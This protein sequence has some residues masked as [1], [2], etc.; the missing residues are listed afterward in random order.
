MSHYKHL[1]TNEREKL[2]VLK[3]NGMGIR[4]IAKQ[5][6]RSAATISRELRRNNSEEGYWP[7]I[8]QQLYS[9]R[10]KSCRRK[11]ILD[12]P[13]KKAF[14]QDK[15]INDQWSPEQIDGRTALENASCHC[16]YATIYRAINAGRMEV[17]ELRHGQRGI[18][19][20]LRHK[21]K[22]RHKKGT[23]EKRG[24]LQISHP[25]EERPQAANDRSERGHFEEDT[26]VGKQGS[27][28]LITL[29]DRM[30]L[31]LLARL[32]ARKTA[33]CVKVGTVKALGVLPPEMVKTITPDRGKEFALHKEITEALGG[34]QFY[35]PPPHAPW[36]RGSNE[37]TNGLL[38][39]YF[40]KS[41]DMN[42]FPPEYLDE[43]VLKLNLRPR[44]RLNWRTPFEA[45]WF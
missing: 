27:A 38:R 42:S 44:K 25:I 6:S 45:F 20:H 14:V 16:S 29:V 3:L 7:S 5:L 40:P 19:M 15:I 12:D 17:S 39:E 37:N 32:A 28:C 22:R 21:G 43:V 2:L 13:V 30:T 18:V 1:T 23:E 34:V 33:E 4:E 24:K 10:R 26:V 9:E 11:F 36:A 35:F 41:V 8:A 31:F